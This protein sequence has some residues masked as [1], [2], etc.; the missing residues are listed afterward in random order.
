L[1]SVTGSLSIIR[2]IDNQTDLIQIPV[3][4]WD[5]GQELRCRFASN[6][7]GYGNECGAAV[8]IF[9]GANITTE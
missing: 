7:Y 1:I 8:E 6:T 9:P 4:D 2:V 5:V 3:V